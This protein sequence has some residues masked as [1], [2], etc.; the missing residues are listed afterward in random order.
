MAAKI[1]ITGAING[2]FAAVFKKVATLHSK[3]AFALA[4]IAGNLFADPQTST[5]EDDENVDALLNGRITIPLPTY[6]SLGSHA[7]PEAVIKKLESSA[8]EL[9]DNL[10]FLGKRTTIKT[11]EG[12]RIVSLGGTLD[13]TASGVSKDKY[14]PSYTTDD[15][16]A[17][18]GANTADILLTN[19][20]PAHIRTGSKAAFPPDT[21]EPASNQAIS[22]LCAALKPRYHFSVSPALFYEREPFFHLPTD[23]STDAKPI[24]RFI[25]LAEYNNAAKAKWLYAFSLDPTAAPSIAIPAGTTASPILATTKKRPNDN[26]SAQPFSRFSHPSQDH[27]PR[28]R[29]R[30]QPPPGPQDCFFCLSNPNLATHLI[31]SI[32]ND[33]YLT[34]AKGPLPTPSTYTSYAPALTFPAHI[35]I[36]PLSHSPT[37]ASIADPAARTSTKREMHH[38]RR[39]LQDMLA[40]TSNGA[41]GAL[42]WEVSRSNGVH[43]HWQV[44]PVAA[45]MVRKGL[46]EAAFRVEAEND[47]YPPLEK[48]T[49]SANNTKGAEEVDDK[50][51]ED[52]EEPDQSDFLRIWIYAPPPPPPPQQ[53]EL[54]SPSPSA[55]PTPT[56]SQPPPP[57]AQPQP[58][59]T[60]LYLPLDPSSFRFDLQYPR[61][62]LAKLL[63][64]EQRVRWQDCAQSHTD[65]V[66]DAEAFKAAFKEYDFSAE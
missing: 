24:T 25:S 62:V 16:K 39:A 66:A 57:P 38:Y 11:S 22:D 26:N 48:K 29:A 17:L 36:I 6:F 43:T 33:A 15:A 10:Y 47:K 34:T 14:T 23:E 42:T 61:R 31:T 37:L 18:R 54:P 1:I 12:V 46:V 27:R 19:S 64:L 7:L 50:D 60:T 45:S 35:L 4:I 9:C 44:L 52:D 8:G 59:K 58:H 20:W 49:P 3:N 63:A 21:P 13:N 53:P 51:A 32:G 30:N 55:D 65:E 5:S 41:L 56:T 28:K 40:T 2:Q